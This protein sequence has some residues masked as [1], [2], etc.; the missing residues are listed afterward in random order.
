LLNFD[1]KIRQ[2]CHRFYLN[3]KM[4]FIKFDEVYWIFGTKCHKV[5]KVCS[6]LDTKFLKVWRQHWTNLCKFVTLCIQS[7]ANLWKFVGFRIP[8]LTNFG[9]LAGLLAGCSV[10][11]WLAAWLDTRRPIARV[12]MLW[13]GVT[14]TPSSRTSNKFVTDW[15][16]NCWSSSDF[17]YKF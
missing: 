15:Y 13:A 17:I 11:G 10:L 5:V 16:N 6:I 2:I 3:S 12:L 7:S 14:C 4:K 1:Y 8:R 9:S